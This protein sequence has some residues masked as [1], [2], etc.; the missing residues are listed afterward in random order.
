MQLSTLS[1]TAGVSDPPV[2]MS[3]PSTTCSSNGTHEVALQWTPPT[4]TGGQEIDHYLVTV[5]GPDGYTCSPDQ[6]NVT[7]TNTTLTEL[8]CGSSYTVTVSA[9]NCIGESNSS[10][11][12]M[13]TA[14]PG[15]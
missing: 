14:T 12:M 3:I 2:L 4:N 6:C 15:Q 13:F 7:A 10:Q 5:T 8:E 9:V 1:V 11:L